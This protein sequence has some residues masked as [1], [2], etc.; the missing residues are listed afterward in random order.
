MNAPTRTA[1]GHPF[2]AAAVVGSFTLALVVLLRVA[3]VF[4]SADGGLRDWFVG[5]GFGLDPGVVQPWW[6]FVVLLPVL[7]GLVW[8]VFETPGLARRVLV[9][10]TAE[11]LLVT[12]S[13][14]AALWG[15]FWSPVGLV[16]AVAWGGGCA[17]LWARQ[18]PMPCELPQGTTTEPDRGK[19]VPMQRKDKADRKKAPRQ[20]SKQGK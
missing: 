6:D 5:R 15:V 20:G 11:V 2:T 4:R 18:H 8:M 13:L 9:L 16:L 7:Y 3:G 17:L 1:H 14:V 12:A 19:I 10:L